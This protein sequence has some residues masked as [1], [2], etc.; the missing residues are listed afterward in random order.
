V[1]D[2]EREIIISI[3][4]EEDALRLSK[5]AANLFHLAYVVRMSSYILKSY[6]A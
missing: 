1:T 3:G 5:L 2:I 4:N 6:F